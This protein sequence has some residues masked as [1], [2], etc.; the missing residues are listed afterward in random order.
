[1]LRKI[2]VIA[3]AAAMLAASASMLLGSAPAAAKDVV[4]IAFIGPLTGGVSAIGLGGR[5]SAE[6][7]VRLRNADIIDLFARLREGD[8]VVIHREAPGIFLPGGAAPGGRPQAF[9]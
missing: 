9:S 7:A 8:E 3:G 4:K 2:A 1:M 6:L 5:N